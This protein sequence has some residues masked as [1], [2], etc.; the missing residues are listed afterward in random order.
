MGCNGVHLMLWALIYELIKAFALADLAVSIEP[1]EITTITGYRGQHYFSFC[2]TFQ[3]KF[4]TEKT[5]IR[6]KPK[7]LQIG[8]L[9]RFTEQETKWRNQTGIITYHVI[10]RYV[11]SHILILSYICM[12]IFADWFKK[13][14]I[15]QLSSL[16]SV[17]CCVHCSSKDSLITPWLWMHSGRLGDI[18][19]LKSLELKIRKPVIPRKFETN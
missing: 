8:W 4:R 19:Y 5:E 17:I 14:F 18:R 15:F 13:L 12:L 6:K 1:S 9:K 2:S 3:H 7:R 16:H 11:Q 10:N